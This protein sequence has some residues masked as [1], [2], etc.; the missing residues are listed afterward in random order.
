MALFRKEPASESQENR[1]FRLESKN[2]ELDREL[3]GL[4]LEYIELYDKVSHQMSR[5]SRR[6]DRAK[7]LEEIPEDVN[8]SD[9]TSES[10]DPISEKI[11]ARRQRISQPI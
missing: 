6:Y 3:R 7:K 5:M 8:N 2:D 10:P 11:L 1:L 4:R 9:S